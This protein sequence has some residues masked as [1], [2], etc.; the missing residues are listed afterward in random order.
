MRPEEDDGYTEFLE[1]VL[2]CG[3][4]E[5]AAEGITKQVIE[6]GEQSLTEKQRFVFQRHVLD[7]FVTAECSQCGIEGIPW[8][9]MMTAHENG[10][11]CGWC[12]KMES[13]DD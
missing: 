7:E 2:A 1:E 12:A 9:E 13:N 4:L 5:G 6:K 8:S 3:G 10:G 11:L